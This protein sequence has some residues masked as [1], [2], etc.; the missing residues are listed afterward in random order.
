M[1][2]NNVHAEFSNWLLCFHNY[3]QLVARTEENEVTIAF[4]DVSARAR[5]I[6]FK[7]EASNQSVINLTIAAVRCL[8]A[9]SG[10]V[11]EVR[12][13]KAR[14]FRV[15]YSSTCRFRGGASSSVDN[16][17][18]VAPVSLQPLS[19]TPGVLVHDGINDAPS[20][21]S[22]PP[23]AAPKR[24]RSDSLSPFLLELAGV[25]IFTALAS[26]NAFVYPT[27]QELD[28]LAPGD[29]ALA[30]RMVCGDGFLFPSFWATILCLVVMLREACIGSHPRCTPGGGALVGE[31]YGEEGAATEALYIDWDAALPTARATSAYI[32]VVFVCYFFL[33]TT[34]GAAVTLLCCWGFTM[35]RVLPVAARR[36]YPMGDRHRFMRFMRRSLLAGVPL[37]LLPTHVFPVILRKWAPD[38]VTFLYPIFLSVVEFLMFSMLYNNNVVAGYCDQSLSIIARFGVA[39][40]EASR[41]G[42]LVVV[43]NSPAG[44]FG[45]LINATLMGLVS[46]AL[47]RNNLITVTC[48][49]TRYVFRWLWSKLMS[50]VS[51]KVWVPPPRPQL[52]KMG[53]FKRVYLGVK[54]DSEYWGVY[55]LVFTKCLGWNISGPSASGMDHNTGELLDVMDCSWYVIGV[56]ALGEIVGDLLAWLV[57]YVMRRY[58][59]SELHV[60]AP[61]ITPEHAGLT[62]VMWINVG[63]L[64]LNGISSMGVLSDSL[65][66]DSV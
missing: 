16:F 18:D 8:F 51:K 17:S 20:T 43:A 21:Q 52:N 11:D 22:C 46:E 1:R 26:L 42:M 45:G 5:K 66:V 65:Q 10:G 48:F 64:F 14:T 28:A 50:A 40:I 55:M 12:I 63:G 27:P 60:I 15:F 44:S 24:F 9:T 56:V 32:L 23:P 59:P 61:V 3:V 49:F 33:G 41:I 29:A 4:S 54:V 31:G 62:I 25:V 37:S 6:Y 58:A 47:S 34:G 39:L 30:M 38:N 35:L 36:W 2:G 57:G 53:R 7:R 19:T 13:A